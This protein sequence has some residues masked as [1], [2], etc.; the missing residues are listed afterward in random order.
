LGKGITFLSGRGGYS[1]KD[2]NIIFAVVTRFEMPKIK[3]IVTQIDEN[4]FIVINDVHEVSGGWMKR[5]NN[6]K[7]LKNNRELNAQ[8]IH[9]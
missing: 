1:G 5:G 4:A 8:K 9:S 7:V 3:Q 2:K 6:Q